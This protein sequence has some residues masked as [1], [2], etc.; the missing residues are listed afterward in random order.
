MLNAAGYV[1]IFGAVPLSFITWLLFAMARRD[2]VPMELVAVL[3]IVCA[4]LW[5]VGVP[6]WWLVGRGSAKQDRT[7]RDVDIVA[8]AQGWTVHQRLRDWESGWTL[9]PLSRIA[10]VTVSPGAFGSRDGITFGVGYLE[11]DVTFAGTEVKAFQTRLAVADVGVALPATTFLMEGFLD[12]LA[13]LVGGT[14]LDVESAEFNR[15]WRV[16]TQDP[17]GSHALLTPR[18]IEFLIEERSPGLAI[19]CDGT[20]IAIW[21]DA[22]SRT[23]DFEDRLDIL[24]GMVERLP[25]FAKRRD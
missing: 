5:L 8:S 16:R 13:K 11:G 19:Q 21:G 24:F 15:H 6:L 10:N 14:D 18:L 4:V 22:R 2:Y 1:V 23:A 9:A 20:R 7:K 17:A 3:A 12:G 25:S